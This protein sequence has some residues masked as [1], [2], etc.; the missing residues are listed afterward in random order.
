LPNI[1]IYWHQED[2]SSVQLWE[3]Q[4]QRVGSSNWEWVQHSEPVDECIECWQS[5]ISVPRTA[6]LVRSR[7]IS[8]DVKSDWSNSMSAL[9]EPSVAVALAVGVIALAWKFR[10][11]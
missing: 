4:F 2:S 3:W 8:F 5:V 9:P 10:N 1:I 6:I 11:A 7:A